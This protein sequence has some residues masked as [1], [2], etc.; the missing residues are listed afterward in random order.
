M[1]ITCRLKYRVRKRWRERER[2]K[3]RVSEC[4]RESKRVQSKESRGCPTG[5]KESGNN[6][7]DHPCL[8]QTRKSTAFRGRSHQLYYPRARTL[9]SPLNSLSGA[10]ERHGSSACGKHGSSVFGRHGS[11]LTIRNE[12][13]VEIEP[14]R[15]GE[16]GRKWACVWHSPI[17]HF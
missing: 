14:K 12:K 2:K 16:R 11:Y 15:E 17:N 13:Q 6:E 10:C 9:C 4:A 5:K 1:A 8:L 3:A 7:T